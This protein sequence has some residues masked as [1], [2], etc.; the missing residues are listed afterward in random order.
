[1]L[2]CHT[3]VVV[4]SVKTLLL[5]NVKGL[6]YLTIDVFTQDILQFRN[7]PDPNNKV[8]PYIHLV[9]HHITFINTGVLT[10]LK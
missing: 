8:S 5:D 7:A 3:E 2:Q 6:K 4:N 1:M 9:N 10:T